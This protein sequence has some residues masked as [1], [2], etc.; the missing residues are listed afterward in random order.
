MSA[1]ASALAYPQSGT[2][3]H[4]SVDLLSFSTVSGIFKNWTV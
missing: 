1:T 3:R 4:L 2:Q